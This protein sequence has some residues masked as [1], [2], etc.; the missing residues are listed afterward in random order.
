[1][2]FLSFV[3]VQNH[4][5]RRADLS[6]RILDTV[7]PKRVEKPGLIL[8][9]LR[10]LGFMQSSLLGGKKFSSE[11]EVAYPRHLAMA[12]SGHIIATTQG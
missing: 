2:T 10:G 5:I 11:H 7:Y 6:S 3:A 4:A 1:M 9:C 12:S 8:R